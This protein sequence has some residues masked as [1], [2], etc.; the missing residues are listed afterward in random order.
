MSITTYAYDVEDRLTDLTAP[1]GT[2]Y[3]FGYDGEGRRTSLTSTAGRETT[4][5]YTNGLLTA[6]SHVQSG[7]PLTDLVYSYDVD[8]QLTGI[9]DGLDPAK[10]LAISYDNLNRLVQVDQGDPA[11]VRLPIEDYAYDGE[12]NRLASHLSSLYSSNAH[13]Q[14]LEDDSY[15]Y[16]YDARGNRVSR[17]EKATGAIETYSYDSQNRLVGYMSV[18][19]TAAYAYDAF[20]RRI[21]KTLDSEVTA[22]VY[23]ASNRYSLPHDDILFEFAGPIAASPVLERR[24]LHGNRVDEPLAFED[25][26][27]SLNSPGDGTVYAVYAD[28]LGS[29]SSVVDTS[30]GSVAAEYVSRSP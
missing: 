1:W 5:A 13:N 29:I 15:T 20:N 23:D 7:V 30:T 2:V 22:F 4:Y 12:G 25:Y 8:A 14:L 21:A 24:W 10:S 3:S 17:T 28:R 19:T 27:A 26:S 9:T 11:G 16:A 18:T 6:L